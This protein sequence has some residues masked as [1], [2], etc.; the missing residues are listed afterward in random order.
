MKAFST[1]M[2]VTA[3]A[4]SE[5]TDYD[6][7]VRGQ[8]IDAVTTNQGERV[9]NPEWGCDIQAMLFDPSSLLERNDTAAYVRDRLIHFLPRAYIRSVSVDASDSEPN[10]VYIEVTYK[11]SAYAPESTVSVGL[12]LSSEATL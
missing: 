8:V 3:G 6:K 12:D 7:I 1:P 5:T 11:P 4:I 10:I 9:M 2:R